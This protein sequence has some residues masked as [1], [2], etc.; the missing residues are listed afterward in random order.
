[1]TMHVNTAARAA[2]QPL[3]VLLVEDQPHSL[4]ALARLLRGAAYEVVTAATCAAA[5]A[6]AT[7]TSCGVDVLVADISLPDCTGFDLLRDL[8]AAC[9]ELPA[10]AI[11]GHHGLHDRCRAAGFAACLEKPVNFTDVKAAIDALVR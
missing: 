8:R 3:R 11:T 10:V 2:A 4:A 5:L 1:M 6:A 7:D 9:G